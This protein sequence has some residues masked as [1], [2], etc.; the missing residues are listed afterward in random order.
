[1]LPPVVEIG[2]WKLEIGGQRRSNFQTPS[3]IAN[4]LHLFYH[5]RREG[6]RQYILKTWMLT[7][8]APRINRG[9]V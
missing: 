4:N 2:D 5:I 8:V 7:A 3:L 1:M 6:R 9:E